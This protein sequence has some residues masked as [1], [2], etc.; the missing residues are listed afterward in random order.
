MKVEIDADELCE[1]RRKAN[2]KMFNHNGI[3]YHADLL[4]ECN[5]LKEE[6]N[7]LL[8]QVGEME[9]MNSRLRSEID[10]VESERDWWRE[11]AVV[12]AGNPGLEKCSRLVLLK[13]FA[14]SNGYEVPE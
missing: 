7:K 14:R 12:L 2:M 1:L 5:K 3:E 11:K 8:N 4:E 10:E 13:E 9:D 6:R